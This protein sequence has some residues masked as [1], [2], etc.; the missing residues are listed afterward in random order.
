MRP[1]S[2]VVV[3]A[4][5]EGWLFFKRGFGVRVPVDTEW[6]ICMAGVRGLIPATK[7]VCFFMAGVRGRGPGGDIS[8]LVE[9]RVSR[10]MV[11]ADTGKP[12]FL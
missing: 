1:G 12:P 5:T 2:G 8:F 9:G 4:A 11:P 6:C 7:E 10:F 3:P